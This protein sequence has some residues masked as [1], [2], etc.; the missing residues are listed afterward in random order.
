LA[1]T[2]LYGLHECVVV[3][4]GTAT[5][6]SIAACSLVIFASTTIDHTT[7]RNF[8]L[9]VA[10]IIKIEIDLLVYSIA[11]GNCGGQG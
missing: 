7:A 1:L 11:W 6:N 5:A 10:L 3:T 2:V 9:C 8:W 4:G